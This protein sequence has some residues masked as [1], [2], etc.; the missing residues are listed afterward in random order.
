MINVIDTPKKVTAAIAANLKQNGVTSV[1]RY[2]AGRD[3]WL[4]KGLTAD[5]AKTIQAAGL[6]LFSIFEK[7]P[8]AVSYFTNAQAMKDAADAMNWAADV[9]QPA[10]T[11]IYFT[12]D[13][14]AQDKDFPAILAYFK[15]LRKYL[16]GFKIGAYGKYDVLNY[17][18]ANNA[19]DYWFQTIAWSGGKRCSFNNLY[20][21]QCDKTMCG[22]DV[23][24]NN[25][26]KDTADIG[27]WNQPKP[28]ES[29]KPAA[30]TSSSAKGI[31]KVVC[32][33]LNVRKAPSTGAEI[34]ETLA[35]GGIFNF[36][37]IKDGWYNLGAGWAFGNN[38]QYLKEYALGQIGTLTVTADLL[39]VRQAPDIN[40]PIVEQLKQGGEFNVYGES[41]GWYNVGAGWV[42]GDYVT[43]QKI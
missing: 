41:Q 37:D 34:V 7:G 1:G 19:A 6:T 27:A 25:I 10:N 30:S 29:V 14:D 26:E 21:F 43:F 32:D 2:L 16:K 18:H 22:I 24:Y 36:Y 40:A 31:V 28:V 35:N 38:G 4:W 13:Y 5:E 11:A 23:D 17:L 33:N 8:T 12:V 3:P 42:F 39:N 15:T 20:Q 9:G